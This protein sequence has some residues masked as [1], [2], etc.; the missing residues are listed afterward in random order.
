M[1]RTIL[2]NLYIPNKFRRICKQCDQCEVVWTI[3]LF[4]KLY[5]DRFK[6]KGIMFKYESINGFPCEGED[7][8]TFGEEIDTQ[9]LN[10]Y[11]PESGD[12][13]LEVSEPQFCDET[14]DVQTKYNPYEYQ[15]IEIPISPQG[16]PDRKN[17]SGDVDFVVEI[18][19][20]RT[21]KK[22]YL[23]S[24]R[25]NRIYVDMLVN[26]SVSFRWDMA[27]MP[28]NAYIRATTVFA[29]VAQAEKR[30]ER[31]YQHS[32][33]SSNTTGASR[34]VIMNVLRSARDYASSDVHYCGVP[35]QADSW[36]SVVVRSPRPTELAYMF[37]CKNSCSSGI[38]RRPI[39]IIFTLE[40]VTGKV[41]GRQSVGAR[42][43]S[44][45]R[46]DIARDEAVEG[47]SPDKRPISASNTTA[48]AQES[49]SKKIRLAVVEKDD[50]VIQLPSIEVVSHRTAQIGLEVMLN[51]MEQSRDAKLSARQSTEALDTHINNL[52][53][54]INN[55][56]TKG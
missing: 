56:K 22:K 5:G 28:E 39:E 31:C 30:V 29:D 7:L 51:M 24:H 50:A 17:F 3:F 52:K 27:K 55:L 12:L 45:P 36:Y 14:M 9:I 44:C 21:K 26:F 37:L 4:T 2:G 53:K 32:H 10:S 11:L 47:V 13:L 35:D 40:D 34:A 1:K 6:I 43:C 20:A 8:T 41:Y 15:N 33:E 49:R 25:L 18:D 19:S 42:V 23:Y 16:P 38:N 46:R 48:P 54:L